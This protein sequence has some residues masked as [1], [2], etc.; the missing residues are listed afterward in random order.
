MEDRRAEGDVENWGLAQEVSENNIGDHSCDILATNVAAFCLCPKNLPE[1]KLKS[2]GL[3]SLAEEISRHKDRLCHMVTSDY[4]G[5]SIVK[6]GKQ[7]KKKENAQF[8]EKRI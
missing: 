6:K 3:L 1:A 4:P 5:R 2:F 8:E 7:D